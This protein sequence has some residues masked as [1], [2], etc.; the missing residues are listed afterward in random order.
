VNKISKILPLTLVSIILASGFSFQQVSAATVYVDGLSPL[1]G[2]GYVVGNHLVAGDLHES[3]NGIGPDGGGISNAGDTLDGVRTYIWDKG[4]VD[5]IAAGTTSRGDSDFAMLIFDMGVPFDSMRLYT[6]QDHI[7]DGANDG[8]LA[9]VTPFVAQDVMEYSV[10]GSN[11][12]DNF[13]LLSD[14]TAFN[15]I[16]DGVGKPTYTFSGTEPTIVYRGGSSELPAD[17]PAVNAYARDYTFD[18]S[19]RYYGIKSST[20]SLAADDADP[21]LD[22]VVGFNAVPVGGEIIPLNTA[23]L[24]LA[25]AQTSAVWMAPLLAG[26]SGTAIIYIKKKRN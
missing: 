6:H 4:A 3:I 23:A 13:V 1:L 11:D 5:A 14:V 8:P 19:Y 24:L 2:S 21:E 10:W 9:I 17:P 18:Q 20:V 26:I 22:A 7:F 15:I 16:G 25:G 12:G